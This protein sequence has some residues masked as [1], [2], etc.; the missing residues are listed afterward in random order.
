MPGHLPSTS[1]RLS[2]PPGHL[3]GCSAYSSLLREEVARRQTLTQTA[4]II[5]AELMF[6]RVTSR[7]V[8]ILQPQG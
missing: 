2:Q 7:V 4:L 6:H 5:A 8:Q 3:G 1:G